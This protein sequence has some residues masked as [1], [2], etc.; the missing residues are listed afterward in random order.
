MRRV[1]L[2]RCFIP[3]MLAANYCAAAETPVD[4]EQLA[5][6][7][8]KIRPVLVKHCYECHAETA[9]NIR[10]ELLLDTRAGSRLGGETGPAVVPGKP[11]ESLLLNAL[12]HEDFE[13]PPSGRL[14]ESV[15]SDFEKWIANGSV[16]PRDGEVARVRQEID[17]EAGRNHWSFQPIQPQAPPNVSKPNWPNTAIDNFVL[18]KLEHAQINPVA[19]CPPTSLLRRAKFDLIG[20]P[21]TPGEIRA[22]VADPS[23]EHFT[24]IVDDWLAS[25]HFGERWGR[26]WL[27]VAR[28]AESSGGGRSLMFPHAWRFRDYIVNAFND[29]RAFD[30]LIREQIAGDLY[31][32]ANPAERDRQL[33]GTGFLALGAINYELQDKELLNLEIVDEQIDTVGR[34]FLGLTLGCA[35]CHDHKFDPIPTTDYY[36][37]AG[38]FVSSESVVHS[39]VS[40]P[41]LQPLE[42]DPVWD[43]IR[44]QKEQIKNLEK[45]IAELKKK[46]QVPLEIPPDTATVEIDNSKAKLKGDWKPSTHVAGYV[47]ENYIHSGEKS[48]E[49]TATATYEFQLPKNGKYTV[50]VSYTPGDNRATNAMAVIHF[51]ENGRIVKRWNQR[52]KPPVHG[53]YVDLGTYDFEKTATVTI[54]KNKADGVVIADAVR[55]VDEKSQARQSAVANSI[56]D[57]LEQLQADLASAKKTL[58]KEPMAMSVREAT[59]V[60]DTPVR[61]RGEIRNLGPMVPRGFVTV[62]TTD[63]PK[64]AA[65]TSGRRELAEWIASPSNPLTARVYVNR[66]WQHLLGAGIVRTPDNFGVTGQPPTHPALLDYLAARFISNGWSTKQLVREIML[67]R[68]YRLS[69]VGDPKIQESDPDNALLSHGNR[70]RLDAEAIRD[71]IL[72]WG[73]DLDLTPGGLTIRKLT[74][75]DYSYKFDTRRRSVYVPRFR[76]ATL[77]VFQV[78]DMANPNLVTGLR[79]SSVLPS[80]ALYL[81]NSP[82]VRDHVFQAAQRLLEQ[83]QETSARID[84]AFLETLG[85]PATVAETGLFEQFLAETAGEAGSGSEENAWATVYHMLVQSLDFRYLD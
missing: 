6:F 64:L 43:S 16:D 80:Q 60:T 38:I 49:E 85:R 11:N 25:P 13:M 59:S 1:D 51:A 27:D 40:N 41:V 67:S 57:Q 81:A 37:L 61:I 78:F 17:L 29:D 22:F 74:A 82:F 77:D 34:S 48:S 18:A 36:A 33:V 50:W 7:E 9:K 28:F 20:L 42:N 39:N 30:Q 32:A 14:P 21:P 5:F 3:L 75:Y 69:S 19:D 79:T 54:R 63:M 12:R 24:N 10:G 46:Q 52:Q 35:R 8:K 4:Q 2:I 76:N 70:R 44:T 66:V 31:E 58:P 56:S 55:L 15:I 26:H 71:S 47:G 53:R 84:A 45:Q 83:H 68:V 62:A 65:D 23:E 72:S 73:G